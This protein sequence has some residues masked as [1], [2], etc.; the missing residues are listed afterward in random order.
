MPQLRPGRGRR[1]TWVSASLQPLVLG[2][3]TLPVLTDP[4]VASNEVE[5][6]VLSA[7][8]H[9]NGPEWPAVLQAA[10]LALGGLD[11]E[12]AA[13]YFQVIWNMLR[14]PMQRALE[15]LAMERQTEGKAT[16]F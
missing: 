6:A 1:S 16:P 2:P 13:V 10:F 11:R 15:A 3:A 5:L 9:G 14:E 7:M 8:A 4:T 12:H